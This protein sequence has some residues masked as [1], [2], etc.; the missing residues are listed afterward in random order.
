MTAYAS[1]SDMTARFG[2]QLLVGLTDRGAVATGEVDAATVEKALVDATEMIDGYLGAYVTPL[3]EVPAPVRGWC[4]VIAIY[5][6]YIT[7]AP[8]KIAADYKAAI[9]SLKDVQAGVIKLKVAG[10]EPPSTG[11]TGVLVT[12]RERPLTEATMKGFI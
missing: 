3:A 5:N 10:V 8:E 2:E 7:E 4:E 1:L 11:G 9:L 12:D 6:L